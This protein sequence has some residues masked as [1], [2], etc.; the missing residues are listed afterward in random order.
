MRWPN[1]GP[2]WR[3][4]AE[5]WLNAMD[6]KMPGDEFRLLFEAAAGEEE[7]LLPDNNC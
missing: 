6:G 5:A 2:K 3:L 4:A 7:M 1:R